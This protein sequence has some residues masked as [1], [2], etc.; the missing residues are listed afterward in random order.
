MS[1]YKKNLGKIGEKLALEYLQKKNFKILMRNFH[2][3]F[4]EIDIIA[5]KDNKLSFVEVKTRLGIEKGCPYEAVNLRKL[6]H[7]KLAAN[8]FLLKNK[9][10]DCKLSIDV[11]SIVLN[12]N[13]DLEKIDFFQ[14]VEL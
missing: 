14:G 3:R 7:L 10:R 2:C 9:I 8:Y 1:L 11:V 5:R 4:S 13:L 12:K 6:K